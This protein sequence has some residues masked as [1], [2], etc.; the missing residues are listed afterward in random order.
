[1]VEIIPYQERWPA[2][3]QQIA[4]TLRRGLGQGNSKVR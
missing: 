4:S 3:F 1:M 2:E